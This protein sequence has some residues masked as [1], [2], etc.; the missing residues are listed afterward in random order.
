MTM[1]F[2]VMLGHSSLSGLLINMTMSFVVM[3]GHV[4]LSGP[5]IN[6]TMSFVV[7]LGHVFLS[8]S[9]DHVL[10]SNAWSYLFFR[11]ETGWS[12]LCLWAG[13]FTQSC[14]ALIMYVFDHC[15]TSFLPLHLGLH[16]VFTYY[17]QNQ[18]LWREETI[19]P[20]P[21]PRWGHP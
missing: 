15:S 4:F 3:L 7:M 5:L 6:M 1:S 20:C 11:H 9:H 8:G 14:P 12:R 13:H 17:F 10:R 21:C 18:I 2:V 16:G 19:G